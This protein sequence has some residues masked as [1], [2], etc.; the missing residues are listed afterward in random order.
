MT[1]LNRPL[2]VEC[3]RDRQRG[4]TLIELMVVVVIVA[5]LGTVA[6]ASYR[7]YVIRAGRTEAKSSLMSTQQG[8]EKCFTRSNSYEADPDGDGTDDCPLAATLTGDGVISGEGRYTI[9]GAVDTLTYTL[10][11]TP[12]AGGGM[13]DD[14]KCETL[15]LDTLG[16]KGSTGSASAAECW[17]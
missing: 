7:N 2:A 1:G 11:A 16:D 6:V 5:V 13:V 17:K 4:V 9:T 3:G 15:T 8:L 10:T 14:A 12:R